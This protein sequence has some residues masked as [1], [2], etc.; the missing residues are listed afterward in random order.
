MSIEQRDSLKEA[1]DVLDGINSTRQPMNPNQNMPRVMEEQQSPDSTMASNMYLQQQHQQQ[2]QQQ[3]SQQQSP[4]STEAS[5]MYQQQQYQ[6]QLQQQAQH[7]SPNS[8]EV[9]NIYPQQQQQLQ[10]LPSQRQQVLARPAGPQGARSSVGQQMSQIQCV[11]P[12]ANG[13]T[14]MGTTNILAL[15]QSVQPGRL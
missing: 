15:Q 2:Q 8:A 6:L 5:N 7:Q 14:G 11:N 9:H 13:L 1:Q 3:P 12:T 10:Q 4:D